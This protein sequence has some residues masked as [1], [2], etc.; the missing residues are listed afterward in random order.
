M[1]VSN[2]QLD[3]QD[4]FLKKKELVKQRVTEIVESFF[5]QIDTIP[6][7]S[8]EIPIFEHSDEIP[9]FEPSDE[10]PNFEPSDEIPPPKSDYISFP[11]QGYELY[12]V[13]E[14]KE[15]FV[16]ANPYKN[17]SGNIA[18]KKTPKAFYEENPMREELEK[19]NQ[20]PGTQK[21]P[22]RLL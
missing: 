8:D 10:I 11:G 20:V 14:K 1:Q 22:V 15:T 17:D 13:Y 2:K 5:N 4:Q 6:L 18:S 9:I 3:S 16:N 7:K 19:S 21:N 12:D